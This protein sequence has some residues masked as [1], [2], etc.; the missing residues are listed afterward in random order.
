MSFW[1]PRYF[2]EAYQRYFFV[3]NSE[4]L[5]LMKHNEADFIGLVV[6]TK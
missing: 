4:I 6:K 3:E 2:T 1:C 5:K